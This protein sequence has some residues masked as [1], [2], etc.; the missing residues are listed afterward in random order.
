MAPENTPLP[1]II[2]DITSTD[3]VEG[4][5]GSHNTAQSRISIRA[6]AKSAIEVRN[7]REAI[8]QVLQGFSGTIG[9]DKILAVVDWTEESIVEDEFELWDGEAQCSV[10]HDVPE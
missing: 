10:W 9:S 1:F 5:S 3:H 2:W 4:L 8:R 6:L 7:L